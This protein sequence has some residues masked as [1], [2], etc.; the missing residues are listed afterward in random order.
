MIIKQENNIPFLSIELKINIP[1]PLETVELNDMVEMLTY[2]KYLL[3]EY[4]LGRIVCAL[5]DTYM[6][7]IFI[8]DGNSILNYLPWTFMQQDDFIKKYGFL[9]PL[10]RHA[11]KL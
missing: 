6:W 7:H 11:Y 1:I 3:D 10:V 4:S 9:Y 8:Y 2:A 5:T